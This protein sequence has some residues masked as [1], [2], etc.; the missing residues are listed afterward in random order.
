[1]NITDILINDRDL[2]FNKLSNDWWK[3]K[4]NNILIFV[5]GL[6]KVIKFDSFGHFASSNEKHFLFTEIC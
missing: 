4:W 6:I 1:M 2:F 3:E 5:E